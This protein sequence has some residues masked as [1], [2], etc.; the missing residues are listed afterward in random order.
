MHPHTLSQLINNIRGVRPLDPS[1][2]GRCAGLV[3]CVAPSLLHLGKKSIGP[4][5]YAQQTYIQP[6]LEQVPESQN[7]EFP[8]QATSELCEGFLS[9]CDLL[10]VEFATRCRFQTQGVAKG[11]ASCICVDRAWIYGLWAQMLGTGLR[12]TLVQ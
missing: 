7:P 8:A 12:I 4:G 9:K 1:R 11:A 5:G 10:R 6:L 3:L 2:R